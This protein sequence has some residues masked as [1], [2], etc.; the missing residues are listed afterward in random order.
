MLLLFAYYTNTRMDMKK[1]TL[2]LIALAGFSLTEG[3]AQQTAPEIDM[4][5][6]RLSLALLPQDTIVLPLGSTCRFSATIR[7][8]E[9]ADR[10]TDENTVITWSSNGSNITLT[11][12]GKTEVVATALAVGEVHVVLSVQIPLTESEQEKNFNNPVL[13]LETPL[14]IF[15][16][17][18]PKLQEYNSVS[19]TLL[20]SLGDS[21]VLSITNDWQN[22]LPESCKHYGEFEWIVPTASSIV[23]TQSSPD[24]HTVNIQGI[25]AG[26]VTIVGQLRKSP[27]VKIT[28]STYVVNPSVTASMSLYL[29]VNSSKKLSMDLLFGEDVSLSD[30]MILTW[31]SQKGHIVSI[32][33]G[34]LTAQ[35]AGID[36]LTATLSSLYYQV[37]KKFIVYVPVLKITP[38]DIYFMNPNDK[39]TF[40]ADITPADLPNGLV[41]WQLS[42]GTQPFAFYPAGIDTSGSKSVDILTS[43]A[44]GDVYL[45][46]WLEANPAIRD[47]CLI[48]AGDFAVV[49]EAGP[50]IV[51]VG[52]KL[53]LETY[54][55]VPF[56]SQL[57]WDSSDP[58]IAQVDATG[59]VTGVKEGFATITAIPANGAS[60]RA[61]I[62]VQVTDPQ[63][64]F[65]GSRTLRPGD[66]RFLS[67]Q[68]VSRYNVIWTSSD[69]DVALV[70][71]NGLLTTFDKTGAVSITA[72]LAITTSVENRD[73]IARS[74][75]FLV[76][77]VMLDKSKLQTL[78]PGSTTDFQATVYPDLALS[79]GLRWSSA[80]TTVAVVDDN[81]H[82]TARN[83]GYTTIIAALVENEAVRGT[84]PLRV[85]VPVQTIEINP[86]H[87]G[88]FERGKGYQFSAAVLPE[89]ATD[90]L[91]QWSSDNPAVVL[92][93]NTGW[94]TAKENGSTSI[95]AKETHSGNVHSYDINVVTP[96]VGLILSAA[97]LSL[98][99]EQDYTLKAY[100]LPT[101]V[102]L[103]AVSWSSSDNSV[104]TVTEN[105]G[106]V[107]ALSSGYAFIKAQANGHSD[108]CLVTVA[109][110]LDSIYLDHGAIALD[111]NKTASFRLNLSFVPESSRGF[112]ENDVEW[113]S[114]DEEIASVRNGLVTPHKEGQV[115][116]FARIG[117]FEAVCLVEVFVPA[118]SI[119]LNY[120]TVVI[121]KGETLPLIAFVIP[122]DA[123]AS[124]RQFVWSSSDESVV[125]VT[126]AGSVEG[127]QG[128][129]AVV[130]ATTIDGKRSVSCF[131]LVETPVEGVQLKEHS[132]SLNRGDS[133]FL[134]YSIVPTNAT[135][136]TPTWRS[137]VE[138][139][140]TVNAQGLVKAVGSGRTTIIATS[141][142]YNAFTDS[143]IITVDNPITSL[144]LP[145]RI[146][147]EKGAQYT[148]DPTSYPADATPQVLD[149]QAEDRRIATVSNGLVQ[150]LRSGVTKVVASTAG[151]QTTETIVTVQVSTA[152]LTLTGVSSL[153]PGF[154]FT[155][156]A[157]LF[158]TDVSQQKVEWEILTEN[159][160]SSFTTAEIV[161]IV[162][163]NDLSCTLHS[164]GPGSV[165][166]K[167]TSADGKV[168]QDR[169]ITVLPPLSN[170]KPFISDN[171]GK[172]SVAH[173]GDGL[174]LL[175]NLSGYQAQ[176]FTMYG[177]PVDAFTVTSDGEHRQLYLPA[178]IYI[179][180]A[181]KGNERFVQKFPVR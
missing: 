52:G 88:D 168:W 21:T 40:I 90:P 125:T 58:S 67:L 63:I 129:K 68:G 120:D 9:Y 19:T 87:E 8:V 169:F 93:D 128:G 142:G 95:R 124:Q 71:A 105:T 70:D 123:T 152:N 85:W 53:Q 17:P 160:K 66:T 177:Q 54:S 127:I 48:V 111:R 131:V 143:C 55:R 51:L 34:T 14:V 149:W 98:R 23:S 74:V 76:S 163:L 27:N 79:V 3:R 77:K 50:A 86:P 104:A 38:S 26:I 167:A 35:Q 81:G 20:F 4:V 162:Q 165:I 91:I 13:L 166:V 135:F 161:R 60:G 62:S 138:H 69:P 59:K 119:Y 172:Q 146:T 65:V 6:T 44:T 42:T 15:V 174:L 24:G 113:N 154:D 158:P 171:G 102:E 153:R 112:Y 56:P 80:D 46:A 130:T 49:P 121:Q 78:S 115:K 137:T 11:Q 141:Q 84:C 159:G 18:Q 132:L 73:P 175:S 134:L 43:Q 176:V 117:D 150:A 57:L 122:A 144:S 82:V 179:F 109:A 140:A 5:K 37:R 148:L 139:V 31:T 147:L 94:M 145:I 133:R 92:I 41:K 114:E 29:P 72:T 100:A 106:L 173:T 32:S 47:S 101:N 75:V 170:D 108:S 156:I 83:T 136:G 2:L 157:H 7:P 12:D 126:G 33:D 30:D 97:S 28:C 61:S 118:D 110:P 36:T 96:T 116:I 164:Q 103:D 99:A 107:Y 89:N 10:L 25:G 16:T 1:A 22:A 151:K 64:V 178:G 181:S 39:Q 45:Y 155:I 180:S